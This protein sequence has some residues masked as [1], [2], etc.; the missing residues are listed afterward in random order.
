[1][2]TYVEGAR[3]EQNLPQILQL[4]HGRCARRG[5]DLIAS[6]SAAT[7]GQVDELSADRDEPDREPRRTA[8]NKA[9]KR[10]W[11]SFAACFSG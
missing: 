9:G 11:K 10:S 4:E 3:H 2:F 8:R 1:M 5:W 6:C 7:P